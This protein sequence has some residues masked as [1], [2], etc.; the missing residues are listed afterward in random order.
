MLQIS[1]SLVVSASP[2]T[3]LDC[4]PRISGAIEGVDIGVVRGHEVSTAGIAHPARV[5]IET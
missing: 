4:V 5:S 2:A 1:G 3:V